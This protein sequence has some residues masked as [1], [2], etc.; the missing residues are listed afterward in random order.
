MPITKPAPAKPSRKRVIAIAS[1][2]SAI[3]KAKQSTP[4][5]AR[6]PEYMTR[7]PNLSTS[8]PAI[9]RAGIV[10]ATLSVSRMTT[11]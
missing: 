3:A 5:I 10:S 1:K 11:C 9:I 7:G 6:R 2:L 4:E 8:M